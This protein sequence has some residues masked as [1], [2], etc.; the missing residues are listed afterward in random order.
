MRKAKVGGTF[1]AAFMDLSGAYDSV[2]RNL[3]FTKL[4]GLGMAA[5]SIS[6]LRSLYEAT[7]CIVKAHQGTHTPFQVGC[8]L[9]QG[10]PLSTTLFNL[11][12]WDLHARLAQTGAG[13]K[14]P[15]A[16]TEHGR[17]LH[18]LLSDMGYA[19]D[20]T[21]CANS[22]PEL[23]Q[24]LDCFGTYCHENGLIINPS[25][26]EVVV[27]AGKRTTWAKLPDWTVGNAKL[28][29]SEKFKYLGVEVHCTQGIKFAVQQRLSCM[30][31][32]QSAVNRRLHELQIPRDPS[33]AAELFDVMVAASGSYGCEIWSTPYLDDWHLWDC[34]LQRHQAATYKHLLGVKRSTSN[35]LVFMEIGK[36]PMQ[37]QWLLRT[38]N[39]WNKL[40]LNQAN[41]ELLRQTLQANVHFGLREGKPCWAKE[42]LAGLQFVEPDR[43]WAS[44][45]LEMKPIESPRAVAQLAK[46][47]FT[48]SILAFDKDPTDPAC[49]SRQHN[50][51]GSLMHT[52]TTSNKLATPAYIKHET[53]LCKK[54][55]VAR[56]RLSGL[57]IQANLDHSTPYEE[58]ICK[59]C[60]C[61]VDN[62][63]HMLL[64]CTHPGLVR[65]RAQ[66]SDLCFAA[67]VKELMAAAYNPKLTE[68]FVNCIHS[69]V[70]IIEG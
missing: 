42:L 10:C 37:V 48:E 16:P 38:A 61:G 20:Y 27:F 25:K 31:G 22:H 2:D 6:T 66:Y 57:P 17:A 68:S 1:C 21:L 50:T 7:Q 55:A 4:E 51:Y 19:D 30:V 65:A 63:H 40:V 46:A 24:L 47:K 35:L 5:H 26:C 67:G 58:R 33:L 41:S 64:A 23:Q 11:F 53:R 62:E 49:P 32:A 70:Q 12:I 34:P 14:M 3:L 45:M 18:T 69:M 56:L 39:Y 36:Y 44:L 60:G 52:A 28:P 8:G 13:A 43:D 29:R 59:R 15:C 9:R 54:Q